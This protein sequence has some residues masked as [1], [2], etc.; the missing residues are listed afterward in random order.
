MNAPPGSG[1]WGSGGGGPGWGGLPPVPV[2]PAAQSR[3]NAPAPPPSVPGHGGAGLHGHTP[4]PSVRL[5]SG[6][7]PDS[8]AGAYGPP[9]AAV[10]PQVGRYELLLELASGGMGAVY[11]GRQR[12]AAGFER[13]VA[14]KRMHPHLTS[15]HGLVA[16]FH[17]EARIASMIHHPNVVNVV[18]VYEEAGEHLLVMEYIDGVALAT[19]IAESRRAGR[20]MPRPVALRIALDTLAG[21]H[22]AHELAN[23]DGRPLEVVH[24]DVSPQNILVALDGTV[25]IT[26]FGIARALERAVHTATGELKGKIRYMAPEQALGQ[27]VD[28]RTDVFAMGIVLWELLAG[29]RYFRGETDIEI[30]RAVAEGQHRALSSIDPTTPAPLESILGRALDLNRENRFPSAAAFAYALESWAW[31]AREP[32]TGADVAEWVR[33]LAG[34]RIAQRRRELS[35]VLTGRRPNMVRTGVHPQIMMPTPTAHGAVLSSP[36]PPKSSATLLV[37]LGIGAAAMGVAGG[38]LFFLRSPRPAQAPPS[39]LEVSTTSTASAS[40]PSDARR[41]KVSLTTGA[42]PLEV[43]GA[44][45]AEVAFTSDGATFTLP[46]GQSPVD[47]EVTLATGERQLESIV[48]SADAAIRVAAPLA[49]ASS[50]A[51]TTARPSR[52]VPGARLPPPATT[53]TGGLRKNP[54]GD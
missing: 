9:S 16:A 24:R 11:V 53:T 38:A 40:S 41:V 39:T 1:G 49:S 5:I 48:P 42:P 22:A 35:D 45:V 28:R 13:V 10:L 43:R 32:A 15:D 34:D 29:E 17:E 30:L 25:R 12:G 3:P 27:P 2:P 23:I 52:P 18:D 51:S 20:K 33:L 31:E 37:V 46:F 44:G 50:S 36:Q 21:L 8:N 47:V 14:I 54:Y 4:T 26:D 19:L 6:L 7:V